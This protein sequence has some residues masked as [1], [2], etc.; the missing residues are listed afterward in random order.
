MSAQE[1]ANAFD[2]VD[3]TLDL[4]RIP[5]I[6]NDEAKVCA[7]VVETLKSCGYTVTTQQV[8]EIEGRH[9]V[10][11]IDA[12][13]RVI[14]TT[15]LDTV[16]PHY[17]PVDEGETLHGRGV[18][19]A[20]GIAAA[21][22]CA[23]E[24]LREKG[25]RRVA[26]LFVVGEETSSDGARAAATGFVPKVDFIIDGEPTDG[27]L[28]RAMKGAMTFAMKAE[29]KACHS[30]YPELGHSAIH[31]LVSD[32]DKLTK[33]TWPADED[34]GPT[35]LNVGVIEGGVAPN[36]L[37]PGAKA[38]LIMRTTAPVDVLED[39]I[40]SEL[41]PKTKLEISSASGPVHLHTVDDD[42]TCV[43]AFGSD[44]PYLS[45][46]GKPLL[47]GPGSIHDAH[48]SHERIKKSDLRDAVEQYVSLCER[49][50]ASIGA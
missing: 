27:L 17:D 47:V 20:K 23:A 4:C 49:L 21:M 36:V 42:P 28:V 40:R 13:P 48:T 15:H 10:L 1:N 14:L 16:P 11:A 24:R 19:D 22:I 12:P 9:N 25:E 45:P 6:T 8:G 34:L 44:V 46:L 39:A 35:T 29:G 41:D 38:E 30:A 43:V 50:L 31:Q 37:A 5:S 3:L 18:L 26:L 33:K 32:L 7:H 2:V